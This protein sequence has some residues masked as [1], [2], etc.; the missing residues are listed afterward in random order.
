M[1]A[2]TYSEY[3]PPEVVEVR[4]LP[5]PEPRDF[6]VLVRV[7]AVAVTSG[8]ARIRAARFP[9]GFGLPARLA[10]GLRR[11]R[12]KV[13]GMT[14]SGVVETAGSKSTSFAQGDEVCGMTGITMGA[15][16][17]YVAVRASKLT[18]KPAGVSHTDAAGILFG[19]TA[20]LYFLRDNCEIKPGNSV[21]INGASGSVGAAAVQL[22]KHLG[23]TVTAVCSSGNFELVQRL[24]AD[25]TVDYRETPVT[26]LPD[27]FDVVFDTV[28]NINRKSG[29]RI[30]NEDGVLLLA[31]ASLGETI[32]PRGRVRSGNG[33]EDPAD[34]E[35]LLG[36]VEHGQLDP[37]TEVL[38]GL[39]HVTEAYE[40]IDSGHKAGNLVLRLTG[41]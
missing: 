36:L 37:V 20:A 23:A 8:D 21:L 41:P 16:A 13:L 33:P 31:V 29:T 34:F 15:H 25:R 38:D 22:A 7:E 35:Y 30:L 6:E 12:R 18:R 2:A 24:G 4:D 14:F 27:R 1:Q 3:G 40:R 26:E 17:E 5:K 39:E 11:P 32:R 19:G 9:R 28:G 10:F